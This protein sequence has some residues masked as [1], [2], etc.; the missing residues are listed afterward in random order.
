MSRAANVVNEPSVAE[1]G[2][3]APH[4]EEEVVQLWDGKTTPVSVW[5]AGR[6][7]VERDPQW[8]GIGP[9]L[10]VAE[11]AAAAND[12]TTLVHFDDPPRRKGKRAS[13]DLELPYA[14]R[15]S[16]DPHFRAPAVD[17]IREGDLE[18]A[19]RVLGNALDRHMRS[20]RVEGPSKP[21]PPRLATIVPLPL[22]ASEPDEAAKGAGEEGR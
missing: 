11:A 18:E 16:G 3:H 10:Y 22:P 1:F 8:C 19:A 9:A 7:S 2:I 5:V 21:L 17:P 12:G 4:V 14:V 13:A 15:P 6:I 20:V